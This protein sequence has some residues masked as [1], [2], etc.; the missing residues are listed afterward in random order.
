MG[1]Y[2]YLDLQIEFKKFNILPLMAIFNDIYETDIITEN[3]KINPLFSEFLND[4]RAY[5]IIDSTIFAEFHDIVELKTSTEIKNYTGTY[6]KFFKLLEFY[7]PVSGKI[8]EK[9]EDMI[10]PNIYEVI[11]G[12]IILIMEGEYEHISI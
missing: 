12:N 2:T 4:R 5:F 10:T 6:K 9:T 8:L 3:M 11:D 1:Y 7:K